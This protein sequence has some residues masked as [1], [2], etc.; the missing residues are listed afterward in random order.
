M[1][2]TYLGFYLKSSLSQITN[3]TCYA[4]SKDK[5]TIYLTFNNYILGFNLKTGEKV[6]SFKMQNSR[7]SALALYD[8]LLSVGFESGA[9]QLINLKVPFNSSE[10]DEKAHK[11]IF[12][13]Q[14][15][16]TSISFNSKGN[17]QITSSSDKTICVQDLISDMTLYKLI[18]HKVSCRLSSFF[19]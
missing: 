1:V 8:S 15:E 18:G 2:K 12:I 3:S 6:S 14:K 4:L 11:V 9:I 19:F 16:I 17:M 7:I 5:K 10:Q 13:H